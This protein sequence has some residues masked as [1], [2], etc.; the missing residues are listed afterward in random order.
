[1]YITS[2]GTQE[3]TPASCTVQ[4]DAQNTEDYTSTLSQKEEPFSGYVKASGALISSCEVQDCFQDST[5][6][7][8][9]VH[10]R[11]K[12]GEKSASASPTRNQASSPNQTD[13]A[14][15][16]KR[17]WSA[18]ATERWARNVKQT[19]IRRPVSATHTHV[20]P[21]LPASMRLQ[22]LV[23]G[24][25]EQ[26]L[27]SEDLKVCTSDLVITVLLH[28]KIDLY[29]GHHPHAPSLRFLFI[30]VRLFHKLCLIP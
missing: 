19:L 10:T 2:A 14:S 15:K 1:M 21:T 3:S 20:V 26:G 4:A 27:C 11:D 9:D 29:P 7:N 23:L 5:Q 6:S 28:C 18:G 22:P 30:A 25:Q 8:P 12:V 13:R 17:C 16:G 24:M